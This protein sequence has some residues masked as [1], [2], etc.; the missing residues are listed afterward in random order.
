MKRTV[1]IIISAHTTW[2]LAAVNIAVYFL[3]AFS[4]VS[5]IGLIVLSG[6]GQPFPAIV[7]Y[8]FVHA[9][10]LHLALNIVALIFCGVWFQTH[11]NCISLLAIYFAAG[12]GGA[13]L[14]MAL[15]SM[16]I[17][18]PTVLV[19]SSAAICGVLGGAI[20]YSKEVRIDLGFRKICL[21]AAPLIIITAIVL[22]SGLISN[23]PGGAVAHI[24][25][26]VIGILISI[27]FTRI[28]KRKSRL[29][30]KAEQSGFASLSQSEK[31][32]LS[33][34]NSSAK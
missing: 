12:V 28:N 7:T 9:S 18:G 22:T 5:P 6:D 27:P 10:P 23:N 4:I 25:G 26:F 13:M 31:I 16:A 1:D 30:V 14:F 21:K 24:A 15:T 11:G 20:V 17:T 33:I 29:I 19:G 3:I 2:L 34:A 8:M 32:G